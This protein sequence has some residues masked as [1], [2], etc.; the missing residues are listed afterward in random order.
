MSTELV[1]CGGC[2]RPYFAHESACPFCSVR[3]SRGAAAT[4]LFMGVM[5]PVVLAACYGSPGWYDDTGLSGDSGSSV[6]LDGDGWTNDLDCDDADEDVN[7]DADEDCGD[8]ID[9]DCDGDID[10]ADEDC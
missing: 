9:N 1:T 8:G 7:P 3:P 5:T 2:S 4:R 6:D 10:A